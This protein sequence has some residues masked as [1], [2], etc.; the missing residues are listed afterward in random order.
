MDLGASHKDIL[1]DNPQVT[2]V[3]S[4][5]SISYNYSHL[6]VSWESPL[7]RDITFRPIHIF[8]HIRDKIKMLH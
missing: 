2:V 1:Q 5:S 7:T 8:Y 6:S 4:E 3:Q